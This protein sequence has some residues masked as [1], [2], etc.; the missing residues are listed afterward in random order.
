MEITKP[1]LHTGVLKHDIGNISYSEDF[2]KSLAKSKDVNIELNDHEGVNIGKV[3]ALEYKNNALYATMDIPDEHLSDEIAFSTDIV[4][5]KYNKIDSN[6][7][8]PV[9]GKLDNVV[10]VNNGNPVRDTRTI[11]RLYNLDDNKGDNNMT[12]SEI[13]KELGALQTK[14]VQLETDYTKLKSDFDKIKE[15]KESLESKL[16]EKES[17]LNDLNTSLGKYKQTE[18]EEK[19]SIIKRLVE[20]DDDPLVEVYKK[21][22]LKEIKLIAERENKSTPPKG[23]SNKIVDQNKGDKSTKKD[24]D[25]EE[26]NYLEAKKAMNII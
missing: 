8:E 26:Y 16:Q 23:V 10:F 25:D 19:D 7:F 22:S 12:D 24:K 13:A 11:T 2:L 20:K 3:K 9:S 4:P 1:I 5:S 14:Y 15:E 6:T 21:M 17:E 18:E